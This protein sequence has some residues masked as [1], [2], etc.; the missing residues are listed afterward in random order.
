[1]PTSE[2][3]SAGF[4]PQ[5]SIVATSGSSTPECPSSFH[6]CTL[7]STNKHTSCIFGRMCKSVAVPHGRLSMLREIQDSRRTGMHLRI[8]RTCHQRSLGIPCCTGCF[9]GA[10]R[11]ALLWMELTSLRSGPLPKLEVD[12]GVRRFVPNGSWTLQRSTTVRSFHARS[13]KEKHS[14]C[15]WQTRR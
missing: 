10:N 7:P 4:L 15:C 9:T 12:H 3:F 1:M 13:T 2:A 5:A 11:D 8:S 14:N 6:S